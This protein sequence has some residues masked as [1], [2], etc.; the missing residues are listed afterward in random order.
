MLR[1]A[2]C[3]DEAAEVS[4]IEGFVRTYDDFDIS[5]Y[6]SSK[7]LVRDIDSGVVF[8]VYLLDVVMPKPSGIELARIIREFDET[9]AIIYLTSHDGHALDAFRVRASQYLVKPV[10]CE[11]LRR[12]LDTALAAV[13]A[14]NAKVFLLKTK[15]GT[16]AI[17][18]HR[19]VCC[20]LVNRALCCVT[21]DGEKRLS[22]TLRAPFDE[23]VAK[24][25]AD[26]RFIR[27]H[28]SFVV[29]MDYIKSIRK[30]ALMM[31]TGASIPIARRAVAELKDKYFEHF[32][33]GERE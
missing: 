23:T 14:K 21:A 30:D 24:L 3:D 31:K 6:T 18:F 32:F 22:V 16:E 29:N 26:S 9:A 25:C 12:E 13:K 15:D 5:A 1:V 11:T 17:P 20:E 19:I 7:E 10:S 28:T 2:I 8:D 33:G 4:R 27:P